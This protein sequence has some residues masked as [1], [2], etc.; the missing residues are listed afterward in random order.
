MKIFFSA[1]EPSGDIHASN[2]IRELRQRDP[3]IQCEGFGGP[4]MASA[5]CDLKY[6]LADHSVMWFTEVLANATTFLSLISQADR[7]FRHHRPDA[8]VL[9]DYPGFNWWMAR[10]AKFHGIPVYYFVPPQIWAWLQYRVEKM[11][12]FV[13]HVLCTLPFEKAW[14]AER[15]VDATYVG[16]PFFDELPLQNLDAGF[17]KEHQPGGDIIA[18][19]PGSRTKEVKH[20]I[21]SLYRT[22]QHIHQ[23]RPDTRFMIACFKP[24]QKEMVDE[25]LRTHAPLPIKTYIA[26]TPEILELAK[27][28]VSVSGS[29]SLEI[30]WRRKP[31]V[32]LYRMT[33][34]FY[35]VAKHFIRVPYITLVNLIAQRAVFPEFPVHQCPAPQM[36]EH[37][38]GWLSDPAKYQA[39]RDELTAL[40]HEVAKPGAC[41]RTADYI[42]ETLR[43][44]KT[45]AA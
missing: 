33:R 15:N 19:L 3:S 24:H 28:V 6:P 18:L 26:R 34:L 41:A 20:N 8:V 38:L 44:S 17:M 43:A 7:Y 23:A 25:Y 4:L 2:L 11:R 29:V 40:C 16:H 45:R 30:M 10:R 35:N 22:A 42:L 39:K 14:Y 12:K 27:A 5:G 32:I 31:T 36:A 21:G 13:D 1:G 9:V 37:V